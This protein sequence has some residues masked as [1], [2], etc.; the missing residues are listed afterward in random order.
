MRGWIGSVTSTVRAEAHS[1]E[2]RPTLVRLAPPPAHSGSPSHPCRCR[3]EKLRATCG[4]TRTR[5]PNH[6]PR[7]PY[8]CVP[9][10]TETL[11]L[12]TVGVGV[13]RSNRSRQMGHVSPSCHS[14]HRRWRR[15]RSEEPDGLTGRASDRWGCL[16][17]KRD[18]N[19]GRSAKAFRRTEDVRWCS[20]SRSWRSWELERWWW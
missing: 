10:R 6:R 13:G 15:F 9:S 18:A 2:V 1:H 20:G 14:K 4:E 12:P 8:R 11:D 7:R 3:A 16:I 5:T 19:E 17:G